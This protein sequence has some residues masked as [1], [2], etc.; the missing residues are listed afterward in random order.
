MWLWWVTRNSSTDEIGER[1]AE[2]PI[3]GQTCTTTSILKLL[4]APL[5]SQ[6]IMR[7][8]RQLIILCDHQNTRYKTSKLCSESANLRQGV[9]PQPNVIRDTNTDFRINPYSYPVVLRLVEVRRL[10]E[11]CALFTLSASF[12]SP[13]VVKIDRW[14][15]EKYANKRR[16]IPYSTTV[17]EV[18][19]GSGIRIRYRITTKR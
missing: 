19:K 12:I 5:T 16:K 15:Y 3:T 13:S 9:E 1:Y 14:L 4:A 7:V 6:R 18:E 10:G 2:M 17:R 8:K 11:V